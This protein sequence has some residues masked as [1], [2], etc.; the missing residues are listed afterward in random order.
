M[1]KVSIVIPVYNVEKYVRRC[2]DSV[3]NQTL[4]EIEIIVVNDGS[5]DNSLKICEEYQR[6][7]KRIKLY[8]K[9]NTGLGLTRN[10]GL[11]KA[12]G[13]FVAFLDSDDYVDLDYYEKLYNKSINNNLDVC[14]SNCK[15]LDDKGM[16]NNSKR[17]KFKSDVINSDDVLDVMLKKIYISGKKI[18]MSSCMALFR[19]KIIDKY[20][21]KFESERKYISEDYLFTI[22]FIHYS[23]RVSYENSVSYYYCYNGSS[24]TRSYKENRFEMS[25]IFIDEM[26]RKLKKYNLLKKYEKDVN[27]LQILYARVSIIQAVKNSG[28]SKEEILCFIENVINDKNVR[29]AVKNKKMEDLKKFVF[30]MLILL[31]LKKVIFLII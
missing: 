20:K 7:D 13:E 27:S 14:Y 2:L 22:D 29:A 17:Y 11:E 19:K 31:R 3:V 6:R 26:K 23:E 10:Y 15:N 4:K 25:K 9:K 12:N 30:D 28:K 1:I 18:P 24:L 16:I 8:S 21:L 5:L